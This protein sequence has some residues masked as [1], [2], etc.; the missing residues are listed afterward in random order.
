MAAI[1]DMGGKTVVVTGATSGIGEVAAQRLAAAGARIVFTARD[2]RRAEATLSSLRP[3]A[4]HEYRL[5]D[6]SSLADMKRVAGEIAAAAPQIDVLINNAGALFARRETSAD[7][8]EMTFATNHMAYFVITNLL[9]AALKAAPAARIVS[10]ASAAH[11]GATLDFADLQSTHGYTAFGAYGRSKLCNILFTRALAKRLGGAVSA[12]CLHPGFVAT[13]FGDSSGG[14]TALAI[15]AAKLAAL[16]PEKGAETILWLAAAPEAA[17]QS[18]GYFDRR[19]PATPSP[20]A[21]DE[22][23]AER[24][25]DAS[26]RLAGV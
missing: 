16:S 22:S 5:A 1:A 13:R 6:L 9:L 18:G 8:L 24:L 20:A 15:R 11:Y 23:A 7:G 4:A 12:N 3:G 21:Q 2:K 17:G 19:Q 25:W 14:A 26:A 10:T